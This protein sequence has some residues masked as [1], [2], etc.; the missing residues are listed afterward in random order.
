MLAT[1]DP[2]DKAGVYTQL[3]LTLTYQPQQ[4]RGLSSLATGLAF[5]PTAA[6]IACMNAV[7]A[8]QDPA[9]RD[10][11]IEPTGSQ[12]PYCNGQANT[13]QP[14]GCPIRRAAASDSCAR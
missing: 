11:V 1:A 7:A 2:V 13:P 12:N 5:L 10:R 8:G 4:Q 6:V 3:G 14:Y 9:R